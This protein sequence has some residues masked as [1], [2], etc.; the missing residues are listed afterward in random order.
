MSYLYILTN[1][2]FNN[3]IKIGYTSKNPHVRAA[4][5]QSTGVPT[6]FYVFKY[7]DIQK[8]LETERDVHRLFSKYRHANNREFFKISPKKAEALIEEFLISYDEIVR[9]RKNRETKKIDL[10]KVY[11]E[12]REV[13][14]EIKKECWRQVEKYF[15]ISYEQC[16]KNRKRLID[17][18]FIGLIGIFYTP[19]SEKEAEKTLNLMMEK[20]SELY[21]IHKANFFK[22]IGLECKI[23]PGGWGDDE[24]TFIDEYIIHEYHDMHLVL[25]NHINNIHDLDSKRLSVE[26]ARE[27][28]HENYLKLKDDIKNK[29]Y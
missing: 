16:L 11:H 1:K 13:R 19:K 7:W 24:F 20:H 6:P 28:W 21:I 15:G 10:R 8:G 22:S 17:T 18:P 29:K 2:S 3:L 14:E 9:K 23:Y 25:Y 4:E 12:W 5:L 26:L 27:Y